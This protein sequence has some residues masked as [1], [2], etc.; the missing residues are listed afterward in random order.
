MAQ[1]MTIKKVGIPKSLY[2]FFYPDLWKTFFETLEIEVILSESTSRK[3]I[4]LA[5]SVA[6]SENCLPIKLF[7]AHILELIDKVDVLFVPRI[8]S[9]IKKHCSC[10]K[11]S[12][13][14][15]VARILAPGKV[16]TF[17]INENKIKLISSLQKF[18]QELGFSNSIA[19]KA[20]NRA[21]NA[22]KK[23][24]EEKEQS[25]KTEASFFIVSH[26]YNL[27]D[28]YIT[29]PVIKKLKKMN[30]SYEIIEFKKEKRK[31][32]AIR[33]DTCGEM[34]DNLFQLDPEKCK[35]VIQISSFNC[36]CDSVM[37]ETSRSVLKEKSI[38]FIVL[39]IDEHSALAG[40][41]TRLEAF[42]DS[43]R[44]KNEQNCNS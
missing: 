21:V 24:T 42:I 34:N 7:D 38:P 26:P 32:D 23:H 1:K 36:G 37:L 9:T 10:P 30:I 11:L 22:T 14:P 19:K 41:D 40:V 27:Y 15:D 12:V 31:K 13:L 29:G 28:D 33:W 20:A 2:Y 39:I 6:E 8:I 17:E 5:S 43:V 18:A 16:I 44:W 4:E 35:G 3:T 25:K